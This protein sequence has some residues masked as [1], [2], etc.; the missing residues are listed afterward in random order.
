MQNV[1]IGLVFPKWV[2]LGKLNEGEFR[3]KIAVCIN[4]NCGCGT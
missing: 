3:R 2:E 4:G 1:P